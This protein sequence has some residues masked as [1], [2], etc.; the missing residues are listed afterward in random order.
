MTAA[1]AETLGMLARQDTAQ[2]TWVVAA[3]VGRDAGSVGHTLNA[4]FR[5]S[6]VTV[7]GAGRW[8]VTDRGRRKAGA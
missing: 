4:L 3:C 5:R 2:P 6:L 7:D 8:L 1:Q